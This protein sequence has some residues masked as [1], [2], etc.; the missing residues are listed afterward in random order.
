MSS[1][2]W[3]DRTRVLKDHDTFAVLGISGDI[4]QIGESRH[5][6]FL[7]GT[8]YLSA[9]S[10]TINSGYP[11]VL[12]SAVREDNLLLTVDMTTPDMGEDHELSIL[13]DRLHIER[14]QFLWQQCC[15]VRLRFTNYH[16][17]AVRF[18][19]DLQFDADYRD[20]FEV[21]GMTREKRGRMQKPAYEPGCLRLGYRGLDEL[22]RS[23]EITLKPVPD[24][25]DASGFHTRIA[26][27]PGEVHDLELQIRSGQRKGTQKEFSEALAT[28]EQAQRSAE[29][30][31]AAVSTSN[32]QFN[33]WLLRSAAD[34]QMLTTETSHGLYPYAG[35]PWFSTPFGR[36]GIIAALETLWVNPELAA[37]VLRYLAA[38]QATSE[39]PL[40]DAQPGKILHETRSGEMAALGEHPFRK[41]YGSVDATPLFVILAGEY[42]RA[43]GDS[44]LLHSIWPNIR[45]AIGWIDTYGDSN[46]DGFVD[47]TR[48]RPDGL[49]NQGWKDS[50]DSVFHADGAMAKA[51][52]ALAEVQGYVYGARQ[53]AAI[54]ADVLG[55]VDFAA[56]QRQLA[57]ELQRRF[58][59]LFWDPELETY[60]LA[61]AEDSRPCRVVSSNPGHCLFTGLIP[62]HR[63]SQVARRLMADDMYS[64]WGIRTLATGQSRYNPMSY[65]NGSVWPHDNGLIAAGLARYDRKQEVVRLLTGFFDAATYLDMQRMPELFC[66]FERRAHHGPTLYP[67]A[68]LPQAWSA[69]TAFMLLGSC[70]GLEVV[71]TENVVRITRPTLPDYL[72]TVRIERLRVGEGEID[73]EFH[74]Y[75][76]DIGVNVLR[77]TSNVD[78]AIIK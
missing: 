73:L 4:L 8:R 65:H 69:A 25:T 30:P 26:L 19:I 22:K 50:H 74:R 7:N 35:V 34:V 3:M 41:Y 13:Q 58:E 18:E 62:E 6:L 71:A 1:S 11:L 55:Y 32:T 12:N 23:T 40:N 49:V 42:H 59:D 48:S 54:L 27:D 31:W 24:E 5:G 68:C 37:G 20:I 21:R 39:D 38:N 75:E 9:L 45:A 57:T 53:A 29:A 33:E 61:L 76:D 51:P 46:G 28:A 63:A 52:L 17:A 43:T 60:V 78:V 2:P 70:L 44:A 14:Q 72:N 36:D 77:R 56:Q 64:G 15:Y 47:Y 10:F 16:D 66:G 67:V